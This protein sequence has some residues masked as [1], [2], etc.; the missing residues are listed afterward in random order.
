[1]ASSSIEKKTNGSQREGEGEAQGPKDP[2]P[3][4]LCNRKC[5]ATNGLP[6][7][8]WENRKRRVWDPALTCKKTTRLGA[9]VASWVTQLVGRNLPAN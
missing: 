8:G 7:S 5:V 3:V 9:P 2:I 4:Q 1:M 6:N